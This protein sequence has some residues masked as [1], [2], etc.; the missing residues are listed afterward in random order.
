MKTEYSTERIDGYCK[1]ERRMSEMPTSHY[2][3]VSENAMAF[4]HQ[5]RRRL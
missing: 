5:K 1:F 4:R 2:G 3:E